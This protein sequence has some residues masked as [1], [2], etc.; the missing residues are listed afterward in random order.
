M[1]LLL[2]LFVLLQL[3]CARRPGLTTADG[4]PDTVLLPAGAAVHKIKARTVILQTGQGHTATTADYTKAGQRS[5]SAAIGTGNT[6]TATTKKAGV[7]LW[8]YVLVGVGSVIG[9]ELVTRRVPAAWLPWRV[10][11]G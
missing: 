5:Q 4:G 11:P 7:P 9:W 1:R 3:A 6:A 2:L 10:R 8:V